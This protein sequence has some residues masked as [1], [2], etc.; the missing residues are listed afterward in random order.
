M[1]RALML[2][3]EDSGVRVSLENVPEARLP[4]GDVLIGVGW[5]SLNYKDGL[6]ITDKSPII[7]GEYPFI[8]G[9]DL[10]GVVL[11]DRSETFKEGTEVILTG[12][13]T[14]EDRWGG[15][16]T[17]ARAQAA[18]LVAVPEGMTVE[19]SMII[20]TAG[21]TAMLA[22]MLLEEHN[23]TPDSGEIVVTGAS[24][25][26]G[27]MAVVLLS[28]LGYEVV[29]STGSAASHEYLFSLG[30]SRIIPREQLGDGVR[31]SLDKGTWAG[32]I[33]AVGGATLAA[34]IS[35][36]KTHGSVA[37][38]G[39][40]QSHKL[41]TT[42]FPFILRGVNLLGIDTNTCPPDRRIDV[43]NRLAEILDE[44][45]YQLVH[46]ATINLEQLEEY[47]DQI[48]EGQIQGRVLVAP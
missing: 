21:F 11:E 35:Q 8:P 28:E 45:H 13:G 36:L 47:S 44:R 33:D 30:A 25:G 22:V 12:W 20:G 48:L 42:V 9:I 17:K 5:S 19:Q 24:G 4:D 46:A 18:H 7:R 2:H 10:A 16:A 3:R 31:R 40:A 29:A 15:Y 6:A 1:F 14:G 43:W 37:S 26:V 38:V 27:S 23:V 32:A 41:E 34:I 39:L